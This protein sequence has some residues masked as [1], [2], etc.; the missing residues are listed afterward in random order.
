MNLMRAFAGE[1]QSRQRYYQAALIA[2]QQK[3]IGLERM[4]RFTAEQEERHAMVFWKLMKDAAGQT[5]DVTA[6]YPADVFEDI[7]QLLDASQKEE[8]KEHVVVYPDFARIADDEGFTEA[9]REFRAIA[10]IEKEHGTRFAYY[11]GLY[12]EGRLF[13]SDDTQQRWICLN[14][15]HIH[16]GSEPPQECPVCSAEQGYFIREAEAAFTSCEVTGK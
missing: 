14:C 10:E 1:C 3:H 12:R 5:V 4:F 15:G 7:G 6:G 13:R 9:A 16:V 8:E 11:A 2:Q